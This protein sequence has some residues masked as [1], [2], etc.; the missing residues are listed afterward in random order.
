VDDSLLDDQVYGQLRRLA[1]KLHGNS[2]ENTLQPTALL[3]EAWMKVSKTDHHYES[4]GHF[5]A[6]AARAMRQILV[7]RARG[8]LR[9]KRGGGWQQVSLTGLGATDA[10]LGLVELDDALTKLAKV[11]AL[12]CEVAQMR[13]F[14]GLT[15]A[16][17]GGVTGKSERSAARK[18]RFARAFLLEVMDAE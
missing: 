18:W 3:H 7:D 1:H 16:E 14:G 15:M 2:F 10:A 17:I 12:A 11:D 9:Q 4:Q 6:V 5:Q 8:R 13:V